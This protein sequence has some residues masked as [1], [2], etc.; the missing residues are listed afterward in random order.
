LADAAAFWRADRGEQTAPWIAQYWSST[1]AEHRQH[2]IS[3]LT[4]VVPNAASIY[5][6]GC[7]CAPN[8]YMLRTRMP[9]LSIAGCDVNEA[10]IA[11]GRELLTRSKI[12][13]ADL[14]CGTIPGATADA[15]DRTYDV[16]L[17]CYAL[18]YVEPEQL[19]ATIAELW[20]ITNKLLVVFEPMAIAPIPPGVGARNEYIEYRHDYL[21]AI[22]SLG[23]R[24]A[25]LE[26]VWFPDNR[27]N[28]LLMVYR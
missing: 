27:I 26:Q 15:P 10:A 21:P 12:V 20:R 16:V 23:A 19:S 14:R 25:R 4:E 5:E 28:G 9:W 24:R 2:L 18:S 6:F 8:L 11:A 13:D 1:H 17:S 22:R 7:H 3:R